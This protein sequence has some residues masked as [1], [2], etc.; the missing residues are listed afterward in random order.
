MQISKGET[1]KHCCRCLMMYESSFLRKNFVLQGHTIKT[2]DTVMFHF[3]SG[4][5]HLFL[6]HVMWPSSICEVYIWHQTSTIV[7]IHHVS[8][9]VLVCC[10]IHLVNERKVISPV[11]E[12]QF[13]CIRKLLHQVIGCIMQHFTYECLVM[14]CLVMDREDCSSQTSRTIV[15]LM[16]IA[17]AISRFII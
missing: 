1:H 4:L 16:S 15:C 12:A 17:K 10:Q 13:F 2:C 7:K 8:I 11:F 3:Y 14:E 5:P 9:L 6:Y